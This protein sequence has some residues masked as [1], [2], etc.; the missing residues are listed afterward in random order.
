MTDMR[1]FDDILGS[2]LLLTANENLDFRLPILALIINAVGLGLSLIVFVMEKI[3]HKT[4]VR[5]AANGTQDKL[6]V[7]YTSTSYH[8]SLSRQSWTWNKERSRRKMLVWK[9]KK[10]LHSLHGYTP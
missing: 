10:Q 8:L 7:N 9:K 6:K 4:M 5:R 2:I 1:S 3:I